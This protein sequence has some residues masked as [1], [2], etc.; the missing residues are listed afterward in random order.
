SYFGRIISKPLLGDNIRPPNEQD[1]LL[2]CRLILIAS[3]ICLGV[4]SC[5]FFLFLCIF[6]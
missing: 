2:A 3:L 6:F 4:F 1:I 5:I